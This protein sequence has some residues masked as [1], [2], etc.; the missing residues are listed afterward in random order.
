M[1]QILVGTL[2]AMTLLLAF[3]GIQKTI[4]R[5]RPHV[6][7]GFRVLVSDLRGNGMLLRDNEWGVTGRPDLVL[8]RRSDKGVVPIEYKMAWKGYQPGTTRRSHQRE[9]GVY[10][11]LCEGDPR[12][13]RRP[14]YGL[15]R[16]VDVEGELVPGGEVRVVNSPD[17]RQDVLRT[18]MGIRRALVTGGP[19]HRTHNS[20]Y[21][22][23][24]CRQRQG[25]QEVKTC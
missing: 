7:R 11:L 6:P 14:E 5:R 20:P 3:C 15:I 12:V 25:C 13:G 4:A 24:H 8:E 9:L 10:L 18:V 21:N 22:C 19:V 17:L 23:R 1:I 2:I 16:Y